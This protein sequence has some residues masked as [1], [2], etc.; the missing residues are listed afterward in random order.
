MESEEPTIHPKIAVEEPKVA[1]VIHPKIVKLKVYVEPEIKQNNHLGIDKVV[2]IHL[3]SFEIL[4]VR[5]SPYKSATIDIVIYTNNKE[6]ERSVVL[7]GEDYLKWSSDD[8]YL[9]TYCREN[10]EKVY[11]NWT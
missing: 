9:Y 2:K 6:I 7:A 11:D 4:R 8:Q 5:V 10:I 3:S 1:L